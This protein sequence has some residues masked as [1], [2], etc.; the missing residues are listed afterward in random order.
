[1]ANTKQIEE[2]LKELNM[3]EEQMNK[4]WKE[5]IDFGYNGTIMLL[6]KSNLSWKALN[7]SVIKQLPYQLEKD[8]IAK[9]IKN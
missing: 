3:T 2:V 5:N 4:C 8:K 1:M 7:P 9:K 6:N